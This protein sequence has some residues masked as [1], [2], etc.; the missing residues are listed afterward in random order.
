MPKPSVVVSDLHLGAPSSAED[1]FIDFLKSWHGRAELVLV[2]GDLFDFWFEY[3]TVV[4]SQHFAVLKAL[5]DL[6]ASGVRLILVGGNHDSWGG[7]FL[8]D[9]IGMRCLDGPVELE[10]GGKR[11]ILAHGDGVG[12]GDVG[13]K[14]LRRTLRSRPFRTL[15]RLVHPDLADRFV[16]RI[17]RTGA[18]SAAERARS[19]VRAKILEEYA[20]EQFETRADIDLVIF[21]HCHIPQ[22]RSFGAGRY[23]INSGDWIEHR[24]YTL[25]TP[26]EVRQREWDGRAPGEAGPA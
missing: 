19:G 21:G 16:Q 18:R 12:P 2:N 1:E 6:A 9:E 20:A 4:P 15:M 10:L 8:E 5:S 11:A 24:T 14:I 7:R 25:V 22:L 3:R 23:Y 13:Y 17:S 26:D